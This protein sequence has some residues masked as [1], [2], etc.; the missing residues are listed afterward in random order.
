MGQLG[1]GLIVAGQQ[2]GQ[3]ED[4]RVPQGCHGNVEC[5][6]RLGITLRDNDS[7]FLGLITTS[8]MASPDI[9]DSCALYTT[10]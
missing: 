1:V 3:R 9:V 7:T 5:S 2:P 4:L 8:T 6:T 10:D